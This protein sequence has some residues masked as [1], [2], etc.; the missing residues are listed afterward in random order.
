M[1]DA[2]ILSSQAEAI[3]AS[4]ILGR[5][6]LTQRLFDFLIECSL[7]GKIPKEIEVAIDAFGR[8]DSFDVSQDAV[9]RVYIHKLR[10]KL[11]EFYAGPGK[12]EA[13]RIVIP[14]GEYRLAIAPNSAAV[15]VSEIV[16][17]VPATPAPRW[18]RWA[19]AL[20]GLSLLV[21]LLLVV[22]GPLQVGK[23]ADPLKQVRESALW[24]PLLDDDLPIYVV[25]G[26]YYIFA[27]VDQ[28]LLVTRLIRDFNINSRDDFERALQ[29]DRSLADKYQDMNL[30][31]LPTASAFALRDVMPV[32]ALAN[33]RVQVV[34]ASDVN[35]NLLKSGHVIYIGYFSGMAT[36]HE[37]VFAGSRLMS[38][39]SYDELYDRT[40][41][42]SY[43]SD[44][45][46]EQ[47]RLKYRD[48]GYVSTFPGPNGNQFVILAGTRD[49]AVM[50]TAEI[51]T[52]AS[53]LRELHA[54][55]PEGSF[56]ALYEVYGFGRTDI[57][58]KLVFTAPL[59]TKA[60]WREAPAQE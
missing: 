39:E 20:L 13:S 4:G 21:N 27:E 35:P 15:A 59:D 41:G 37:V 7:K 40:T 11:E 31:Y 6:S 9:V 5:S 29:N 56:E 10:R 25:T 33:R 26:D 47:G 14:R 58:A 53:A 46:S 60:I 55:R 17:V 30:A 3:R 57:D 48:Y 22:T 1:S 54:L 50:R 18:Y 8:R 28:F 32:L 52:Q 23:A 45:G 36:L 2:D 12:Q 43:V 38:G 19:G 34:M 16:P 44:V 24:A 51:A 42:T 49:I